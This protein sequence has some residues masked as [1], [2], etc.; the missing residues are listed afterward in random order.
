MAR[1]EFAFFGNLKTFRSPIS[2][3]EIVVKLWNGSIVL[4]ISRDG[5]NCKT[6]GSMFYITPSNA[7]AKK[8]YTGSFNQV[9]IKLQYAN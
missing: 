6:N 2:S 8:S 4:E 1:N 3:N 7:P 5:L 9:T